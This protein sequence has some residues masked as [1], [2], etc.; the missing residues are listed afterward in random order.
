MV[1]AFERELAE[2]PNLA[3]MPGPHKRY[4]L[5]RSFMVWQEASNH[6]DQVF[7]VRDWTEEFGGVLSARLAIARP[8]N[9]NAW[10]T[11]IPVHSFLGI[12]S[13]ISLYE[14]E[15]SLWPSS[16]HLLQMLCTCKVCFE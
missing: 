12:V 8:T 11:L 15:S 6:G 16:N 2:D 5:F 4:G 14:Q 7:L 1:A 3:A 9:F 13:I 10:T